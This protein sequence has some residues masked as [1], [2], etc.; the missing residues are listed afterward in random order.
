[1]RCGRVRLITRR[2]RK[3]S[4]KAKADLDADSSSSTLLPIPSF[5]FMGIGELVDQLLITCARAARY[6]TPQ[7]VL[8]IK[9]NMLAVQQALCVVV[10]DPS[11]A[12]LP[13]A[14]TYW[15]LYEMGPK[16]G[17][18]NQREPPGPTDPPFSGHAGKPADW[19][20]ALYL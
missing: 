5:L 12:D 10:D 6:V 2:S 20:T 1:M 16:V 14:R 11:R 7:G 13:R 15:A 19:Q 17:V 4:R 3:V 9:R 18:S 8:K